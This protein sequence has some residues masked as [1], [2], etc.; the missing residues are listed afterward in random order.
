MSVS[1]S[2]HL[3]RS[4]PPG[5][6]RV[7]AGGK[8]P[9]LFV[10]ELHSIV[11]THRVSTN[12]ATDRRLAGFQVSAAGSMGSRRRFPGKSPFSPD[13]FPEVESMVIRRFHSGF[14]EEPPYCFPQW[15][16]Q[17]TTPPTVH[18]G[19]MGVPF[20]HVLTTAYC[21]VALGREPF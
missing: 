21:F 19:C 4:P 10:A 5:S 3:A 16:C 2:R 1:D 8:I 20:V 7:V 13:I 14:S 15:L 11:H 18:G 12:S 6:L 9:F 17:H